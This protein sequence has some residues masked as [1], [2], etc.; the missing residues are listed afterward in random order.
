MSAALWDR[1]RADGL[2]AGDRPVDPR[3]AA[4]WY[5][6]VMLGIAGWIGALFLILFVGAAF[7]SLL[8]DAFA[9]ALV[10]ALCCAAAWFLFRRFGGRDFADQFALVISLVGQAL[11]IYGIGQALDPID[12]PFLLAV[13][14]TQA[15]LAWAISNFLHRVLASA[16][17]ALA[18]ALTV[19]Q[20][21]LHGLAS[22]LLC[23]AFAWVWLDPARWAAG[24]G[25]WRPVGYGLALALVLV[26]TVR[27]FGLAALFGSAEDPAGWFVLHGPLLG[28]ILTAAVLVWAALALV[29]RE[30][31]EPGDRLGR[32]AL[33]LAI[34]LALV[35]LAAPGLGAALLILLLGFAAGHRI[36]VALGILGLL[37]FV[38]HF[39]YSLHAT[40]LEKS[41]L[42]ALTGLALIA[43]YLLLR[44]AARP[45]G[46][47][48]A[49][50]A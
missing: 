43:I 46:R 11:L 44:H 5:V 13:A 33:G 28:R 36:L 31:L 2:V 29:R 42:L 24:G 3:P 50:H 8:D 49:G 9:S 38:S 45:S 17:T 12:P 32:L 4:P 22:P 41:G 23:L 15:V 18:L 35:S 19:G 40:L 21:G 47:M 26:E 6:R 7:A 34:L 48:E 27:L 14:A 1:L 39:Y 30:G 20:L 16:G 25:L 10:G 37:G